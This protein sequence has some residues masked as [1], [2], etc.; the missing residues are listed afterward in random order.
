[1]LETPSGMPVEGVFYSRLDRSL[2]R[3][4]QCCVS[5]PSCSTHSE[6]VS[7]RPHCHP[8]QTH[9]FRRPN[10]HRAGFCPFS[11][12][13]C[14]LKVMPLYAGFHFLD[15][16][17]EFPGNVEWE[18]DGAYNSTPLPFL[19]VWENNPRSWECPTGDHFGVW[20]QWCCRIPIRAKNSLATSYFSDSPINNFASS[21]AT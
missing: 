15:L 18:P 21:D 4:C 2:Q 13:P 1:M 17:H 11:R 5:P 19:L 8:S 6:A 9:Y 16:V 14:S 7:P 20:K 10:A 12:L 3:Y